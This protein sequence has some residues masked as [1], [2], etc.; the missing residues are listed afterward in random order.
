M[1]RARLLFF[2]F[3]LGVLAFV[4]LFR[5]GFGSWFV[6]SFYAHHHGYEAKHVHIDLMS[7]IRLYV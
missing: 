7:S 1:F 3:V 2:T 5:V 6:R 4:I